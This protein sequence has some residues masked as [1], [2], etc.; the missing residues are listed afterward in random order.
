[1]VRSNFSARSGKTEAESHYLVPGMTVRHW[2][3]GL[4]LI[5][6][7]ASDSETN[8]IFVIYHPIERPSSHYIR[9]YDEFVGKVGDVWRFEEIDIPKYCL[10][11]KK[12]GYETDIAKHCKYIEKHN[13]YFS[14]NGENPKEL[15]VG[16]FCKL[17][18]K[19]KGRIIQECKKC[20]C[21][22]LVDGDV[23][24]RNI[25]E[26]DENVN[27]IKPCLFCGETYKMKT[28]YNMGSESYRVCCGNCFAAGPL[29]DTL[30]EAWEKWNSR[31]GY[32]SERDR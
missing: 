21:L 23:Q 11:G 31:S 16:Y 24:K 7:F 15:Y 28:L 3:G 30:E 26:V 14:K 22:E 27:M 6:N 19:M 32:E 13:G 8:E 25:G 12:G 4:Y 1:M 2:K 18:N 5:D 20:D 17:H 9:L 29:A 10:V